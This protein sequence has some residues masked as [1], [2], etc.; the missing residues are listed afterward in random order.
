MPHPATTNAAT[1]APAHAGLPAAEARGPPAA[2][3]EADARDATTATHKTGAGDGESSVQGQSPSGPGGVA[4]RRDEERRRFLP[5]VFPRGVPDAGAE[6][7]KAPLRSSAGSAG[8]GC[9]GGG[10]LCS[11]GDA[12]QQ[13]CALPVDVR[14]VS[15]RDPGV[16]PQRDLQA[17]PGWDDHRDDAQFE[18]ACG[19]GASPCARP[20]G[21]GV[22]QICNGRQLVG[23]HE[24]SCSCA[25]R[26]H[27][28]TPE[29]HEGDS[30]R[31]TFP[32]PCKEA[33][34]DI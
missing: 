31:G 6:P 21:P 7:P 3:A 29:K 22:W 17:R 23:Q 16:V 13:R 10:T 27:R 33:E 34:P 12:R 30:K 20:L 28:I 11:R 24:C 18:G 1:A 32:L 15:Y 9:G 14:A 26:L 2:R 5:I 19:N 4:G 8:Q 25:A